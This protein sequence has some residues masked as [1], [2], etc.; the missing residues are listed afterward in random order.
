MLGLF[1][2][3][4][5]VDYKPGEAN[6]LPEYSHLSSAGKPCLH[7]KTVLPCPTLTGREQT[8]SLVFNVDGD[9]NNDF[10]IADRTTQPSLVWYQRTDSEWKRHIIDN[11]QLPIEAGGDFFDID[12][13]GD[14]DIAFGGDYKSNQLWWW[15]NPAPDF[16]QHWHRHKIKAGGA[17]MHHDLMFG[18][19][20]GDG[21]NELVFWNQKAEKLFLAEVPLNPQLQENWKIKPIFNATSKKFEGLAKADIN[22]DGVDDIVASGQWFHYANDQFEVEKIDSSMSYTRAVAGQLIEGGWP[23]TVFV[24]GDCDG[25][26]KMYEYWNGSW[27]EKTLIDNV[28][29]GHSLRLADMN[30]DGHMDI[31]VAEM[32]LNNA[33]PKAKIRILYGDGK[34][35]FIT[36]EL[37]NGMGNHESRVA[38]LDGDGDMDI[39]S[40]PYNWQTPR[41]DIWLNEG[42]KKKS[43][44]LKL[45]QWERHLIGTLSHNG[46]HIVYADFD[47]DG[48]IDLAAADSWFKNPGKINGTWEKNGIGSSVN[49]VAFAFDINRDGYIDLLATEG[50][51]ATAN[52]QLLWAENTISGFKPHHNI[53]NKGNGDFLQGVSYFSDAH[54]ILLSWHNGGGGLFGLELAAQNNSDDLMVKKLSSITQSEDISV[55]DIDNDGD[56]DILLGTQYL[57]NQAGQFEVV[58]MGVVNDYDQ[59]AEPDRNDLADINGDGKLD[60]VV[61]LEKGTHVFWFEQLTPTE[62]KRHT[63]TAELLGQGFSM[64]VADLDQDG[65]SDIVVGEHSGRPN[66]RVLIFENKNQGNEW[67]QI[68]IDNDSAKTIDH[69]DG[70]QLVDMDKDG[71]LDIV[72]IGWYNQKIWIYEN[73]AIP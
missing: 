40:K 62:W 72:S 68:V 25:P 60:V 42:V 54:Q 48:L 58:N 53:A 15:E 24:C 52:N 70:T 43:A 46:T 61:A 57:R 10:V 9:H 34:G 36:Q 18:D 4:L 6:Q 55:A 50:K 12:N 66:N 29:H 37:A 41:I 22:L 26:L 7:V 3:F 64:D 20:T 28:I 73:K 13:D 65:D 39:L 23:E 32:R 14:L 30:G 44:V 21:N 67:G 31:F 35:E 33:N 45:D 2:I 49:N 63:V 8:A 1:F 59:K 51:G 11:D 17:K 27:R 47:R 19:F 69:H 16:S 56:Q 38:D 5:V 71:D